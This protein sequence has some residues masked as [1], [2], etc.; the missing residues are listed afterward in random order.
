MGPGRQKLNTA[1]QSHRDE[2]LVPPGHL[3]RRWTSDLVLQTGL[4]D[5]TIELVLPLC[6]RV[7]NA[8]SLEK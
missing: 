7:G 5:V 6:F 8:H 3:A 2:Q 1:S 4:L